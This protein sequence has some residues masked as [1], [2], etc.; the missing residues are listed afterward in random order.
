M[1]GLP[2]ASPSNALVRIEVDGS[3]AQDTEVALRRGAGLTM[4]QFSTLA[5]RP[6][7]WVADKLAVDPTR[8]KSLIEEF[9]GDNDRRQKALDEL[10]YNQNGFSSRCKSLQRYCGR[11]LQLAR[12]R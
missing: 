6:I 5:A 3:D 12:S 1:E 2:V 4:F 7:E 10:Y 11:L 8:S 9:F